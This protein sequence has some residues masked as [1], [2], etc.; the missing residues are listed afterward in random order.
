MIKKGILILSVLILA[1][2]AMHYLDVIDLPLLPPWFKVGSEEE[3]P[4]FELSA[5]SS[6]KTLKNWVG[7][8]TITA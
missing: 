1:S 5:N 8:S 2:V 4:D 3:E 7:S 6:R